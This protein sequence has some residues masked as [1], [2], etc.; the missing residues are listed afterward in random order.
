M[1]K[2]ENAD[3]EDTNIIRLAKPRKK[4]ILSFIFSRFLFI[5]ILLGLQVALY[6]SI[7]V[8]LYQYTRHYLVIATLFTLV[9]VIYLFLSSIDNSAKLTWMFIISVVP[10]VGAI[11]LW[12][13]QMNIGHRMLREMA[14][15]MI[16]DTKNA[17]SQP[18]Q[19]M[20]ELNAEG[21]GTDDLSRYLNRSGC[22][23]VFKNTEVRYFPLGEDKFA[24][25]LEE[26][27]KA[28]QFIFMEYFI[29]EEGYMWGKIL[30][31]L[32]RKARAGVDVRVMY[33]GM[34]EMSTLPADY[35]KLLEKQGIKAKS[36]A[37]IVPILSSH[38]NYRDHRKI[39]VIDGKTAFNGGVNLADEYINRKE[40]FGHWKD[41]AVMLKGDAVRSFTLLFLSEMAQTPVPSRPHST[42]AETA[43]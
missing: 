40:R 1:I 3:L 39:L 24:A 38:Y 32:I 26:L 21:G 9:M 27:E 14:E 30:E 6:I 4:G 5:A 16:D 13:T 41:T 34:C 20:K 42:S 36:F 10:F 33:D 28:E 2:K 8:W 18:E 37:P 35:W 17:I 23:P 29:L 22:F 25:M 12:Y 31:I 15:K 19:V 11:L 43:A 7:F